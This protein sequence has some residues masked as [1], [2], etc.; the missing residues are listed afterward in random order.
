MAD[1]NVEL[2]I[3]ANR[4]VRSG[5]VKY[6]QFTLQLA[7]GVLRL[8]DEIADLRI[9]YEAL[10]ATAVR[11]HPSTVDTCEC[12]VAGTFE[13]WDAYDTSALQKENA[14]LRS[15]IESFKKLERDRWGNAREAF[16]LKE[17]KE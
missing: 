6:T 10:R 5:E 4:V 17:K 16:G 11:C 14:T 9:H 8:L 13:G 1:E 15:Q 3:L 12:R 2:K 7:A